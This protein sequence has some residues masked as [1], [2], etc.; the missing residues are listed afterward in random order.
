MK[1]N[2]KI[3][4]LSF[5][6][7]ISTL[8]I[9]I[10]VRGSDK[11][12][13]FDQ[14]VMEYVHNRTTPLG[15][16]IMGKITYFG[17]VYFFLP[18]GILI[19]FIMITT[20]NKNG[21]ILLLLSTSGSYGLNFA[22]KNI[23]IRTRP[24]KYFLIE[25]SG[26]SFPSGH[27]MVSMTFYTTMTYLLLKNKDSNKVGKILWIINFIV[28]GLIG[29]SRVYLGVHWPTDILIGYLLGYIFYYYMTYIF[30]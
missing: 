12:I 14:K 22:L 4:F 5:I 7:I 24:L 27:A 17:S 26:Y 16:D 10:I 25:Q 15:I 23:I 29:F 9:G 8:V 21:I 2:R 11:G 20:K 13:L 6:A 19:F 3:I 18:I 28:V 30:P 1:K